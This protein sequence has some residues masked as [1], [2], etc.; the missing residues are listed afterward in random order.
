MSFQLIP[1]TQPEI[2][3]SL[4]SWSGFFLKPT[5]SRSIYGPLYQGNGAELTENRKDLGPDIVDNLNG[6]KEKLPGIIE[7][8]QKQ[9]PVEAILIDE[10]FFTC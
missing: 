8:I 10:Y 5:L 6:I 2:T 3:G 7:S 1:E 4:K 9:T